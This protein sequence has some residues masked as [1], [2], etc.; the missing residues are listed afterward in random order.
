M[1]GGLA[2]ALGWRSNFAALAILGGAVLAA[3]LLVLRETHHYY[4]VARVRRL[5][6]E[7]AAAAI[8]GEVHVPRFDPPYQPLL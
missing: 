1:G 6:G 3:Q 5:E 2:Q 8:V 4:A 7:A